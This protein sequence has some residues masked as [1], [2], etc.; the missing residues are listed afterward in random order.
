MG[1]ALIFSGL[2]N[3]SY[4]LAKDTQQPFQPVGQWRLNTLA[5][6][7]S[8]SRDFLRDE[9]KVTLSIKRIHPGTAV[10]FA[11]IGAAISSSGGSL[12]AGFVPARELTT[13]DRVAQA[14]IGERDGVVFAGSLLP[15][16]EYGQTPLDAQDVT[17]FVVTDAAG[18]TTVL[19]TRAIDKAVVALDN[20]VRAKLLEFGLDSMPMRGSRPMFDRLIRPNG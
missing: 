16:E 3:P 11:V 15:R 5:D 2:A 20:C 6:G 7:C 17:D 19:H 14:S 13:F 18:R 12:E 4:S 8:V 10:Q 9:Q 1:T